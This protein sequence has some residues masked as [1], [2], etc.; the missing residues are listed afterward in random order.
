MR[1]RL[2]QRALL[3]PL[4]TIHFGVADHNAPYNYTAADLNDWVTAEKQMDYITY[5]FAFFCPNTTGTKGGDPNG[6]SPT[7]WMLDRPL[8]NESEPMAM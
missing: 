3:R 1:A 4:I 6:P 5:S 8:C 7:F 2:V